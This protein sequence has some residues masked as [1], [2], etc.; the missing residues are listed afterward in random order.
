MNAVNEK[1]QSVPA[2]RPSFS[3]AS[4]AQNAVDRGWEIVGSLFFGGL[5]KLLF[6][7]NALDY[8]SRPRAERAAIREFQRQE[9]KRLS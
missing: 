9:H 7:E 1:V 6:I 2:V 4:A 5:R 3:L 8:F